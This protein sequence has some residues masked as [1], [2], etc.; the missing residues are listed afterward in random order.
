MDEQKVKKVLK[1]ILKRYGTKLLPARDRGKAK[2][3]VSDLLPKYIIRMS[4]WCL[5][6]PWKRTFSGFF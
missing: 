1:E 3:A 5:A 2:S 4:I 6:M